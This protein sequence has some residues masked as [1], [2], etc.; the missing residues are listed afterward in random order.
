MNSESRATSKQ[1]I[2]GLLDVASRNL[3]DAQVEQL[4]LDGRF[5]CAYEAGLM[6]AAEKS[7]STAGRKNVPVVAS[8]LP[9][10]GS[11]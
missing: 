5:N 3:G 6:L 4:S 9:H 2:A 10:P 8:F 7:D 11:H 1:E